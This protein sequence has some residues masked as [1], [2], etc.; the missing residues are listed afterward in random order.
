MI[1]SASPRMLREHLPLL[2]ERLGDRPIRR[3][4][5]RPSSFAEAAQQRGV[6]GFKEDED[7]IERLRRRA[8]AARPA[9]TRG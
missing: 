5:M 3:Q 2:L 7:R 9:G 1:S 6:A 8:A 4:R